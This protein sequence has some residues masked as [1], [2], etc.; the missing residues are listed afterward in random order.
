MADIL[1][2]CSQNP[3]QSCRPTCE[4]RKFK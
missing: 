1:L 2:C 4:Y 3:K